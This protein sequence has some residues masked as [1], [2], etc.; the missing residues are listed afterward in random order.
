MGVKPP[1]PGDDV[2]P[3][4]VKRLHVVVIPVNRMFVGGGHVADAVVFN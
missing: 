2:S 1:E 3:L 4:E